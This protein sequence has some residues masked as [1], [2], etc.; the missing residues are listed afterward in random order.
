MLRRFCAD[1]FGEVLFHR[2]QWEELCKRVH[3]VSESLDR[4]FE[5]R[6]QTTP[7]RAVERAVTGLRAAF[8]A[9]GAKI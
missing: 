6:H 8:A 3:E 4:I 7:I 5:T 1:E 9:I 2:A